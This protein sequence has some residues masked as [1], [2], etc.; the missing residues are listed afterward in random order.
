MPIASQKMSK[1][2]IQFRDPVKINSTGNDLAAQAIGA[3][4]HVNQ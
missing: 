3:M 4:G 1:R 2:T